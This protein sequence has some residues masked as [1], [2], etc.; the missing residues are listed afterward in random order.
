MLKRKRK[1]NKQ[2]LIESSLMYGMFRVNVTKYRAFQELAGYHGP[3]L[4]AQMVADAL[5][6]FPN[7]SDRTTCSIW[8]F[9]CWGLT[10]YCDEWRDASDHIPR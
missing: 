8:G 3:A 5:S 7:N 9:V 10:G 1:L 2:T 4:A 6:R